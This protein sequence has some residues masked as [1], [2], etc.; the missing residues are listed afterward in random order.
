[1]SGSVGLVPT[2]DATES[3]THFVPTSAATEPLP[4]F[5]SCTN[6]QCASDIAYMLSDAVIGVSYLVLT[7]LIYYLKSQV[8]LSVHA[9]NHDELVHIASVASLLIMMFVGACGSVHLLMAASLLLH[10]SRPSE[11]VFIYYIETAATIMRTFNTFISHKAQHFLEE[12]Y[13][14]LGRWIGR[15]PQMSMLIGFLILISGLPGSFLL[16]GEASV[17]WI[18][19]DTRMYENFAIQD[20]KFYTEYE[21][22]IHLN[23]GAHHPPRTGLLVFTPRESHP[24]K[25]DLLGKPF[26]SDVLDI[27]NYMYNDIKVEDPRDASRKVAG[28]VSASRRFTTISRYVVAF[29][30]VG[31]SVSARS[32]PTIQI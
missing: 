13:S 24:S 4:H 29:A 19:F 25:A 20:N 14:A 26:L 3:L 27:L 21:D 32:Y 11:S 7:A 6:F 10:G 30:W 15:R 5:V 23:H 22:A 1:M 18:K 2:G 17:L 8:R 9:G 12:K 16:E 31:D 28:G